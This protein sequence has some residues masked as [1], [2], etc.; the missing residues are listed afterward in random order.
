MDSDDEMMVHHFMEEED[1]ATADE[2]EHLTILACFP[3]LQANELSNITPS[4]GGSKFG[5]RKAKER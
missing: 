1:S 3:E 5:R 4:R 2:D